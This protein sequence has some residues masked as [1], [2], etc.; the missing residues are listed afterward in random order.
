VDAQAHG[1]SDSVL[2]ASEMFR[3]L[4]W[5]KASFDD[6]ALPVISGSRRARGQWRGVY[7]QGRILCMMFQVGGAGD[8]SSRNHDP[9]TWMSRRKGY[10]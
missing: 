2:V 1:G 8:P 9:F 4:L 7:M 10:Y 6:S 3:S 5:G